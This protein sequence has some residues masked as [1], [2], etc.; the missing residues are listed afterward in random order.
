[1]KRAAK[2]ATKTLFCTACGEQL[3]VYAFAAEAK[4][5]RKARESSARCERIGKKRGRMCAKQFI[6]DPN[7]LSF[8]FH[9]K[10]QLRPKKGHVVSLKK[11]IMRKISKGDA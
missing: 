11:S 4:N 6:A 7:S 2:R 5:P 8:T 1:M 9:P 10:A 3:D